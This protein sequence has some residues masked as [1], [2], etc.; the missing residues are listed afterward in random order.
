LHMVELM[1]LPPHNSA[2]EKSRIVYPSR[3][4]L[5]KRPL[6]KCCCCCSW[7][8]EHSRS[9]AIPVS[10]LS[11]TMALPSSST[12]SHDMTQPLDGIIITSPGTSLLDVTSHV[13]MYHTHIPI[14]SLMSLCSTYTYLCTHHHFILPKE[15]ITNQTSHPIVEHI[16]QTFFLQL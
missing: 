9:S 4:G 12:A 6:N 11:S 13:S 8:Q 2:S 10:I 1:P 16:S 7:R 3:Y 5:E 15:N 14:Y